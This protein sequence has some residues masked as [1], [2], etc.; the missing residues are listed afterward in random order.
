MKTL[1][2]Q[3]VEDAPG[4]VLPGTVISLFATAA[5]PLVEVLAAGG[6]DAL[7]IFAAMKTLWES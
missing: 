3:V 2:L 7:A 4:V 5:R 6:A 1:E